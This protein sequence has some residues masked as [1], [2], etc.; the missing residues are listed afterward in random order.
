MNKSSWT[1]DFFL[2]KVIKPAKAATVATKPMTMIVTEAPI[3]PP[4]PAD[5]PEPEPEDVEPE[6]PSLATEAV[7]AGTPAM[8]TAEPLTA[9][10]PPSYCDPPIFSSS[11]AMSNVEE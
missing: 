6:S 10:C 7:D 5:I 8:D 11:L 4:A 3:S 9:G 2:P 1:K